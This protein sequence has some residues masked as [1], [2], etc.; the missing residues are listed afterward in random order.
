VHEEYGIPRGWSIE[1]NIAAMPMWQLP[2]LPGQCAMG[3]HLPR[4]V[5]RSRLLYPSGTTPRFVAELVVVGAPITPHSSG[6]YGGE[7]CA[8]GIAAPDSPPAACGRISLTARD[9]R[10]FKVREGS[11]H[12]RAKLPGAAGSGTGTDLYERLGG[13]SPDPLPHFENSAA[14]VVAQDFRGSTAQ[15]N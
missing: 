7:C 1:K 12:R 15:R 4:E 3:T 5:R 9:G 8:S 11:S 6:T 14:V 13:L 2:D 10:G